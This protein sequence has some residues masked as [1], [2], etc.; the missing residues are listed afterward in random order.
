[1]LVPRASASCWPMWT[2]TWVRGCTCGRGWDTDPTGKLSSAARTTDP[3]CKAQA[4]NGTV[5]GYGQLDIECGATCSVAPS[6]IRALD[7]LAMRRQ[8]PMAA[9]SDVVRWVKI[10]GTARDLRISL[11]SPGHVWKPTS[12]RG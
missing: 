1:M 11:Y 10:A 9:S 4:V 8:S 5:C 12:C 7:I 2:L 6:R 3:T